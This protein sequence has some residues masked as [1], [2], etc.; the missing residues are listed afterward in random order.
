MKNLFDKARSNI[1][2]FYKDCNGKKLKIAGFG[3]R[4]DPSRIRN[5]D[6]VIIVLPGIFLK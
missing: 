5:S 1:N 4:L 2:D 3:R 6:F